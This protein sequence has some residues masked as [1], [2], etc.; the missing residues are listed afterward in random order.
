MANRKRPAIMFLFVFLLSL[1]SSQPAGATDASLKIS[2][3]EGFGG[4][5]K[6]GEGFPVKITAENS[7]DDFSGTLLISFFPS[8]NTSGT[9]PV[10]I[11][12]PAGETRT[13]SVNVP[14]MTD[15]HSYNYQNAQQIHLYKGNWQA[16][17]KVGYKGDQAIKP[18]YVDNG[19]KLVGVLSENYDRLKELRSLPSINITMIEIAAD[20]I[21]KQALGLESLDYLIIDEFAISQLDDQQQ[22][23][24][25]AWVKNG[26]VLV[27]GAAPN[28]GQ[29]YGLLY[30]TLPLQLDQENRASAD[31]LTVRSNTEK[32]FNELQF[33]TGSVKPEAEVLAKSGELPAAVKLA[34]GNGVILQTAFSLGD[35]PI[36]AWKGYRDWFD[37][38]LKNGDSAVMMTNN[39]YGDDYYAQMYW[40]FAEAN[41][42]FKA[43]NYSIITLVTLL[44]VYI[45]LVVPVLYFLLRK[46]DKR[47]HTW[48]IIPAVS[49]LM[50]A[51]IF[52]LGAKDRISGPQLNQ[53]GAYL[54]MNDQLTGVQASTLMSN[55]SGTYSLSYPSG[56]FS[57]VSSSMNSST[58]D[59]LRGTIFEEK[60]KRSE[61]IFPKVE[62]WAVRTIYG[63]ASKAN[64]GSFETNLTMKNGRLT[65]TIVNQ[66]DYDFEEVFIWS[67]N[68]QIK[69]GALKKGEKLSV[70]QEVKQK[71]LVQPQQYGYG[72]INYSQTDMKKMKLE[73]LR[74]AAS[75]YVL[76]NQQVNQPVLAGITDQAILDVQVEGKKAKQD[77]LNLLL[78]PVEVNQQYTG[79][80]SL[81]QDMLGKE[82]D[83]ING[84]IYEQ[85]GVYSNNEASIEDGE[86]DYILQLPE[87]VVKEKFSIKELSISFQNN[88]IEYVLLN[89]ETNEWLPL[90]T[91]KSVKLTASENADDY[92]SADGKMTIKLKKKT[93]G[94]SSVQLPSVTLKGE[95]SP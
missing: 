34:Y 41:E 39:P 83:V 38:F 67:G 61:A 89:T 20:E 49:V 79:E 60:V 90:E 80:F 6:R 77:N 42:F 18:K 93:N 30:E 10:Q 13:F 59:P 63:K 24:I 31:F 74:N 29:A 91:D 46:W 45:I 64:A 21:P 66:F 94:D 8:H 2:I 54:L 3:D 81:K 51:G 86:Y 68:A 23:A 11:E 57:P 5:V 7:G 28:A 40:N 76:S 12:V 1:F 19:R 4:M 88:L 26:G 44:A 25:E 56:E 37:G 78:M 22:T 70:D 43:A 72:G 17:N 35:E 52:G 95:V 36:S 69:L 84:Q 53:I 32:S 50:A 82:L 9:I 16:G 62:Y 58:F 75:S 15:S 92:I 71:M 48:W 65:G 47:E 33:F 27:A 87:A 14:G 85:I 73:Q 55:T